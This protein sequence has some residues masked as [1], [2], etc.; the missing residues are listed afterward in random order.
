[1]PSSS[2][3]LT[4]LASVYRGGGWVNAAQGLCLSSQ[5]SPCVIGE[6]GSSS[7]CSASSRLLHTLEKVLKQHNL[8]IGSQCNFFI[9]ALNIYR[10][11]F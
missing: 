6:D 9:G 7:D 10:G 1:M 5:Y 11:S 2:I 3:F 4:R 8:P